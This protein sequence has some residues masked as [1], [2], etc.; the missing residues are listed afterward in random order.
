MRIKNEFYRYFA[1]IFGGADLMMAL[2][3]KSMYE[4]TT[5]KPNRDINVCILIHLI[6][7]CLGKMVDRPTDI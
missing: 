1:G 3:E 2:K 7:A 5:I 6:A 4:V